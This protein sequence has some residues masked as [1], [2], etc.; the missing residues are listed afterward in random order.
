[1][2]FR[3]LHRVLCRHS[4]AADQLNQLCLD[5]SSQLP[6]SFDIFGS[7]GRAVLGMLPGQCGFAR[8]IVDPEFRLNKD[9]TISV[10][11]GP[12]LGVVVNEP[13]LDGYTVARDV[14]RI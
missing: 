11:Q 13:V 8:D 9:G 3:C 5:F 6:S 1:M 14:I 7:L 2:R 12:G 10:P 4:H